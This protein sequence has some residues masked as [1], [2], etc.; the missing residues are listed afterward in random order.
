MVEPT[1]S[2]PICGSDA[3][4]AGKERCGWLAL[5][6]EWAAARA[7]IERAGKARGPDGSADR[8][9][10][11]RHSVGQQSLLSRLARQGSHRGARGSTTAKL[12]GLVFLGDL[13][14]T[15]LD[16]KTEIGFVKTIDAELRQIQGG[17][18]LRPREPLHL[19]ADETGI[20]RRDRRE[21]RRRIRS[22]RADF[23]SS[24]S[25][26]AFAR[27]ASRMAARTTIG[28]TPTFPRTSKSGL[29]P[30][31]RPPTRK[32]SCSS[33]SGSTSK[34]IMASTSKRRSARFSKESG[35]VLAVLMGHSHKNDYRQ[36]AGIHYC[37]LRAV[38]RR[39]RRRS[40]RK[41][42][43]FGH[44]RSAPKRHNQAGW[45]RATDRT[46][47]GPRRAGCAGRNRLN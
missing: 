29:P 47:I 11:R 31:W 1:E 5:R 38:D 33:T 40:R 9:P 17:P 19:V 13:V 42:Q 8:H 39:P 37:V 12:D 30:I 14:D 28:R 44:A 41:E 27:T 16:V 32:R 7:P 35:K 36:I 45:L 23:I 18:P 25:T 6:A 24:S 10:L 46:M 22:T 3:L 15:G 34:G 20:R 4:S 26:P 21:D 43:R 2:G